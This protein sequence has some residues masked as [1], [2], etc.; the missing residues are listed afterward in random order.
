M[1]TYKTGRRDINGAKTWIV[2]D[3]DNNI[4]LGKIS[5]SG[6]DYGWGFVNTSDTK[7]LTN[8]MEHIVSFLQTRDAEPGDP[9]RGFEI[10]L[11]DLINAY[12][13]EAFS[14]TPDYILAEYVIG[15]LDAFETAVNKRKPHDTTRGE[16]LTASSHT[17]SAGPVEITFTAD[18]IDH[19]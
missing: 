3:N 14:D 6:L 16:K 5:F 7:I 17:I 12:N 9:R 4:E 10:Q 11:R 15:C 2:V 18:E 1:I 8:E 13:K 19:D